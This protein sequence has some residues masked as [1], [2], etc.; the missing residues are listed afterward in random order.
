M[1]VV[2]RGAAVYASTLETTKKSTVSTPPDDRGL[3]A[4]KA[5][6]RFGQR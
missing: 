2:G 6:L 3:R 1:T 4:P 5:G